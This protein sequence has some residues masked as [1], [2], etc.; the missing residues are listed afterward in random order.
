MSRM[1]SGKRPTVKTA[2]RRMLK[3]T[4]DKRLSIRLR[5]VLM[6]FGGQK[7]SVIAE[8]AGCSTKTVRRVVNRFVEQGITGLYDRREDN[9]DL[10]LDEAYLGR[11]KEI[12]DLT[13]LEFGYYRPTWTRELLV[14]VMRRERLLA[15]KEIPIRPVRSRS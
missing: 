9:G 11:L 12:V 4:N 13:P 15:A 10:K 8:S 14:E 1:V 7:V 2:L 6:N 5:I 3:K